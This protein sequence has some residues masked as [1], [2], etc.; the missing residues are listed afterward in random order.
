MNL[1]NVR[2]LFAAQYAAPYLGNFLNSLSEL[3]KTLKR[4]FNAD[5]AYLFPV[6]A[7]K[8]KWYDDFT[9]IH[10][11]YLSGNE[12]TLIF[13]NEAD[14]ILKD[15]VPTIIHTHFDGYDLPLDK[16]VKRNK[17]DTRQ[18]WHM[19][20][21]LS[22]HS[23]ILKHIYQK[24]CFFKHYGLPMMKLSHLKRPSII[25]VCDHERRFIKGFR[26]G[27]RIKQAVIHNGIDLA[28]LN[29]FL[30]KEGKRF[31]FLAFGGRNIQK[32]TDL[33][34]KAL[35][36][37]NKE[38]ELT[39]VGGAEIT[40]IAKHLMIG[41]IPPQ[42]KFIL[43]IISPTENVSEFYSNADCFISSSVHETFSYAVAEASI[44]GLP[45][46]QSNIEGT[47]WNSS[48]PSTFEFI[49]GDVKSL[50]NAIEKVLDEDSK[51]LERKCK[52]TAETNRKKLSLQNWCN[53]VIDF[54]ESI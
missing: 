28:R 6:K 3:E 51:E 9:S 42:P 24:Y 27:T 33:I 18:I 47:E 5:C 44:A 53:K 48:N 52:I 16:A 4:R 43:R 50:A 31:R 38:V 23:N 21:F 12:N 25:A 17:M 11:V 54:Y 40:N 30:H 19:H 36:K 29:V 8:Q 10:K 34:I 41:T 15:F 45:V 39:I 26:L 1:T 7:S 13:A 14:R 37:L 20:D 22:Y 32:R 49:S 2:I 46:I 35:I